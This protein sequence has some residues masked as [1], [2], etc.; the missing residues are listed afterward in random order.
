MKKLLSTIYALLISDSVYRG[1]LRIIQKNPL[2]NTGLPDFES[3]HRSHFEGAMNAVLKKNRATIK[4]LLKTTNPTWE[5]TLAPHKDEIQL[6]FVWSIIDHLY[7]V[8]NSKKMRPIYKRCQDKLNAYITEMGQN[9]ALYKAFKTVKEN[10]YDQLGVEERKVIDN[11]MRDFHLSGIDLEGEARSRYGE[12]KTAL[13][14][15]ESDFSEKVMDATRAWTLHRTEA[16]MLA[17]LPDMALA[18][19]QKTAKDKDLPGYLLT[20]D[21]TCFQSVLTYADDPE[22]RHQMYSAYTTRASDQG[23][24]AGQFD[25]SANMEQIMT[26]RHELALLL[27]FE[28]YAALSLATKMA[29]S[30]DEVLSFLGQLAERARPQALRELA[31]LTEYAHQH[32]A[33]DGE[34][35]SWDVSYYSEKLR[36]ERYQIDQEKLRPYFPLPRVLSGLFAV[37]ELLYGIKVV[38]QTGVKVWHKDVQFFHIYDKDGLLRGKFYTDLCE[39]ENKRGGA[40]MAPFIQRWRH[41]DIVEAP[42]CFINCNFAPAVGND[43]VLITHEDTVTLFHEFGHGLHHMLTQVDLPSISGINGVQWDAVELPSQYNEQWCWLA[44]SIA[45]ISGHYQTGEALSTEAI[46]GLL[47]AK[48]FQSAMQTLRQIEFAMFDFRLHCSAGPFDQSTIQQTMDQVRAEVAVKTPPSDNRFQLAFSHIFAGGYAAGYYSYKW[49]EVLSS[50]AFSLFEEQPDIFDATT[51]RAFLHCIL[52]MGGSED[53]MDL[54]DKF[55]GRKPTIDALIRH[56]GLS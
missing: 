37:V 23:P 8:R 11:A 39:R 36:Q 40:W 12:I 3:I 54:F 5:E 51:G 49:A 9:E 24:N 30:T 1:L 2:L 22:V 46:D 33:G 56:S 6:D 38:E 7:A 15:L 14:N 53:M 26:L 18:I 55:R 34:L 44:R 16:S 42:I 31:E 45:M 32:G 35:N 20:L 28:N 19:A 41:G 25:N 52:E 43:P 13:S 47:A 50:D 17:G 21:Q 4:A 48:N 27:G 29:K 10:E